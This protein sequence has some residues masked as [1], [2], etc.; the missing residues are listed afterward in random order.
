MKMVLVHG[1]WLGPWCFARVM[2]LLMAAGLDVVAPDLPVTARCMAEWVDVVLAATG[3]APAVLVGHS[4]GGA[5]ISAVAEAAPERVARLVFLSGFLLRDGQSV[6]AAAR[7]DVL[8]AMAVDRARQSCA[9]TQAALP[10]VYGGCSAEDA[11]FAT[12]RLRAEPLFGLTGKLRLT[13]A[14]FGRVPRDYI[15]C[16]QDEVISLAAQR[17]MQKQWPVQRVVTLDTGH[18]P[19]LSDPAALAAALI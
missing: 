9:L 15:E 11:A 3:G 16:A 19:F 12:A 14:R 7:D 5:V 4:R 8:L 13:A 17:R 2:P 6:L 1:A 18:C 10:L